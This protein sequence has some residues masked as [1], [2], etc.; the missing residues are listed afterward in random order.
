MGS[1]HQ[2]V[3]MITGAGSGLGRETAFLFA[4]EGARVAICDRDEAS[5][6][7]VG[8]ALQEAQ[9]EVLAVTSDVSQEEQVA[10]FV[11]QVLNHYGHIDILIN[12][13]AV[14]EYCH[15]VDLPL[16]SWL[17]HFQNNAT[18]AFLMSRAVVP[19]M[20]KQKKGLIINLTSGLAQ[21]GAAG[22]GAYSASKAAVEMLTY[23][24]D[25]E[26]S[27]H[28]I[29]VLAFDPGVMRTGMQ[30]VGEDPAVVAPKLL[31]LVQRAAQ[32][33]S[34]RVVRIEQVS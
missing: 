22:F 7:A 33:D 17:Y 31:T 9:R 26:E 34:S 18:S 4:A 1:L 29:K 21:T 25:E 27:K 16:D 32:F 6:K 13:A 20:R 24:L 14:F 2:Q 10:A 19:L 11:D 28:N 12:N 8:Q 5:I 3:V 15:I 30:G 23:S